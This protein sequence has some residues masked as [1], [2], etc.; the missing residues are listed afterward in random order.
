MSGIF[1]SY[2]RADAAGWA[3]RLATDLFERFGRDAVFQD[4]EAISAGEDFAKVIERTL[5]TCSAVLVLIGPN[6]ATVENSDGSLRLDDPTDTVRI[7]IAMALRREGV[8]VI[9]IL[10]GGAK[11]PEDRD[12]PT[13][14]KLLAG[15]NALELSDTRWNYDLDKLAESLADTVGLTPVE[16]SVDK[17]GSRTRTKWLF[18]ALTIVLA[19]T[20]TIIGYISFKPSNRV[21]VFEIFSIDSPSNGQ[22]IPL[23]ETP[24][25]MV[26]GRLKLTDEIKEVN[27]KPNIEVEVIRLPGGEPVLPQSGRVVY[28]TERGFWEF[29]T[30]RFSGEGRYKVRAT[31]SVDGWTDF[32]SVLVKC[33]SKGTAFEQAIKKDREA[34]GAPTLGTVNI[35]A[36]QL[37][38]I[39]RE[40]HALQQEFF[41]LFPGD[42]DGAE[43]N[44]ARTLDL[45]DP[46]LP[47]YPNDWYLQNVRAY[48]FKNYAMVMRNR[49]NA[50][51]FRRALEEADGMF[52]TIREQ[53]PDDAGAW[54]GL[55]SVSLLKG[56]PER[57]L[58]YIDRALEI[59]PNYDAAIHDR[60]IAVKMIEAKKKENEK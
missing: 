38:R 7:E 14:L 44:I 59:L 57:A 33:T 36:T 5:S 56:E 30:A 4:I 29:N 15:R 20:M 31:V 46:M 27:R 35:D 45:L 37:P 26:E 12:L 43:S 60:K 32:Q 8:L 23:G 49:G 24:T 22:E 2:R 9:P 39:K 50:D 21:P 11:M 47:S 53:K 17:P 10:V 34:R 13:D 42:L 25:R 18:T 6:W 48:T 16:K 28:S 55:G 54:N 3:G 58:V 40:L 19:I 1:I 52:K 41:R 51:E